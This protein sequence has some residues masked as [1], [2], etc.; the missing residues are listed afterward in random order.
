MDNI[1]TPNMEVTGL[2]ELSKKLDRLQAKDSQM[3]EQI[4]KIIKQALKDARKLVQ[5]DAATALK[6]KDPRHAAKAVRTMIYKQI[7]GGNINILRKRKAG[8]GKSG[9]EP[10][11]TL[12]QGQ[13]GGNRATR[14]ARTQQLMDYSGTD[15]GFILIWLNSGTGDRTI[16]NFRTD[17]H[18]A[19]VNRGSQG[20]D[21]N[22]YGKKVNSGNRG[23]VGARNWFSTSAQSAMKQA[24]EYLADEIERL[25]AETFGK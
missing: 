14:S 13:R 2:D 22:K 25:I 12:R 24:A 18:R 20:G 11:R 8:S 1:K 15:R 21:V 19:K 16:R 3:E 10:P 17:E 5:S 9:Y 23:S 4:V 6:G 7:L